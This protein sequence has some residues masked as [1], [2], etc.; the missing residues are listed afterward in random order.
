M[1]SCKGFNPNKVYSYIMIS[2]TISRVT[3][4]CESTAQ[5]E[6]MIYTTITCQSTLE[7]L[8]ENT[9]STDTV[10]LSLMLYNTDGVI[11]CFF[12]VDSGSSQFWLSLSGLVV[13]CKPKAN[14]GFNSYVLDNEDKR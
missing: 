3:V 2:D 9:S 5:T 8:I 14:V 11:I 13:W 7:I 1:V 4:S 6:R 12:L 10:S